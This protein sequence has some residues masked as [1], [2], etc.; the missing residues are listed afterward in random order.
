MPSSAIRDDTILAT[1]LDRWLAART[2]RTD[3]IATITRP[4]SGWTNETLVITLADGDRVVV[5]IPALTASF[6]DDRLTV[7]A[8]IL[9]IL[10]DRGIALP[11]L[12]AR[13]LDPGFIG[14]PFVVMAFVPG[15]T[16][17]EVPALEPWVANATVATQQG[18][19]GGFVDQLARLHTIAVDEPHGNPPPQLRRGLAAELEYWTLYVEWAADG[20]APAA[21]LVDALQW[22]ADHSPAP[23]PPPSFLWGDARLGNVLFDDD[24]GV[25]ALLDWELATIGPAEMDLAWYLVLDELTTKIVGQRVD[26]FFAR[27]AL[28]TRYEHAIGRPVHNLAWHEVFALARSIAINDRQARVARTTGVEYP[29]VAGDENPMLRVLAR[30]IERYERALER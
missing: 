24:A 19:L 22:C 2:D 16:A 29:G 5:R 15:R 20:D 14:V 11:A 9:E 25:A 23:E 28:L 18:I 6:P 13:E 8:H 1:G 12:I 7:E 17:G 30:R 3:R 26:G 10:H 4:S 21:A 27:D